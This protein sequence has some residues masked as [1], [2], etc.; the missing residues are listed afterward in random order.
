[1]LL[2]STV[3]CSRD[4]NF[5]PFAMNWLVGLWFMPNGLVGQIKNFF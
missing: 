5:D 1:M 4:A 2:Y 3:D